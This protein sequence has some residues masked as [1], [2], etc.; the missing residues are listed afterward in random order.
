MSENLI[1]HILKDLQIQ[2]CEEVEKLLEPF[3]EDYDDYSDKLLKLL[4]SVDL[5]KIIKK[6]SLPLDI[7]SLHKINL[8]GVH[9]LQLIEAEDV[10]KAKSRNRFYFN[11]DLSKMEQVSITTPSKN[12]MM[13]LILTD[14]TNVCSAMEYRYMP[15]LDE[16]ISFW[17][18]YTEHIEKNGDSNQRDNNAHILV[19]LSGEPEIKRGVMLLLPGMLTFIMH[20][21][22]EQSVHDRVKKLNENIGEKSTS[23]SSSSILSENLVKKPIKT[24]EGILDIRSYSNFVITNSGLKEKKDNQIFEENYKVISNQ[25]ALNQVNSDSFLSNSLIEDELLLEKLEIKDECFIEPDNSN[26]DSNS[27]IEIFPKSIE[28]KENEILDV[29]IVDDL[30]GYFDFENYA[31]IEIREDLEYQDENFE[32]L[33][34]YYPDINNNH[35]FNLSEAPSVLQTNSESLNEIDHP[36]NEDE[37]VIWVEAVVINSRRSVNS[38]EMLLELGIHYPIPLPKPWDELLLE[39]VCLTRQVAERILSIENNEGSSECSNPN[40][41]IDNLLLYVRFIQGNIC[42]NASFDSSNKLKIVNLVGFVPT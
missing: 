40:F 32:G 12:R 11:S 14:G 41:T 25:K 18:K 16:F 7:H 33:N 29:G 24:P 17:C 42:L 37:L 26:S 19:L 13:K 6:G 15:E 38:D 22:A 30:Q 2:V 1:E 10:S 28:E 31:D 3:K 9:L 8:K 39:D 34:S 36:Q 35:E 21:D 27:V 4:L 20:K 5:S 23:N